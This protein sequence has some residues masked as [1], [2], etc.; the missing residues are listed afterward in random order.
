MVVD[1]YPLIEN[2]WSIHSSNIRR[3]LKSKHTITW[4]WCSIFG[5]RIV[6]IAARHTMYG[7]FFFGSFY[8][9][10]VT[11]RQATA[12]EAPILVLAPHS[13][14]FDSISV[15]LFGPPSVLAKSETASLPFLGSK[16]LCDNN[17]K[18][19]NHLHCW[20]LISI[21]CFGSFRFVLFTELI[22]FTQPI[23]VTRED[24]NSRQ[25]TIKT[26]IERA[27]SR[28]NWSQII[29]FPEG[30]CTN[31]SC[32]LSFKPGAFFPGVAVQPVCI[33]YPNEFD[34]VTWTWEGPS[35]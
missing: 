18:W 34:T 12:K 10:K 29:I 15:V 31:R 11:G 7:M 27:N 13:S 6:Q 28:D 2:F 23:Y 19:Q 4:I 24:P 25:R 16:L 32:I 14:F 9:V 26:V 5:N 1:F 22:N 21:Y 30:T 20:Y 33:R 17:N 35:A 8:R 3:S